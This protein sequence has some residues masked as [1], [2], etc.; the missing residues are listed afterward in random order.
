[1]RRF[2]AGELSSA[3]ASSIKVRPLKE[4]L[5]GPPSFGFALSSDGTEFSLLTVAAAAADVERLACR[6]LQS[7]RKRCPFFADVFRDVYR[8]ARPRPEHRP[9]SAASLVSRSA[10]PRSLLAAAFVSVDVVAFPADS[11]HRQIGRVLTTA[12]RFKPKA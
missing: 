2:S 8:S 4:D 9:V 1:M 7:V 11:D 10:F 3:T 12:R 5:A 6:F